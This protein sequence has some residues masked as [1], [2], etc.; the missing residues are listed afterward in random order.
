MQFIEVVANGDSRSAELV[1]KV[2]ES[3]PAFTENNL[4][5]L[6]APLFGHHSI[7]NLLFDGSVAVCILNWH[8]SV[9]LDHGN[10]RLSVLLPFAFYCGL[11]SAPNPLIILF[12]S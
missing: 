4:Q 11:R 10:L 3:Y 2:I 6:R 9:C 12:V 7:R 8:V 5:N 1:H